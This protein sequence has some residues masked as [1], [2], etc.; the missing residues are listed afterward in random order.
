MKRRVFPR[1]R[2]SRDRPCYI[3]RE[4]LAKI[5]CPL[6]LAY[7]NYVSKINIKLGTII[8]VCMVG[9]LLNFSKFFSYMKND[10]KHRMKKVES[11]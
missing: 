3:A 4:P 5:I 6:V 9:E 11:A 10:V 7:Q 8:Y 2:S 1:S